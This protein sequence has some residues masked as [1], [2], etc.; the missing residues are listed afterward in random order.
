MKMA[1]NQPGFTNLHIM[2]HTAT[3]PVPRGNPRPEIQTQLVTDQDDPE[4]FPS[5]KLV[6]PVMKAEIIPSTELEMQELTTLPSPQMASTYAPSM[7]SNLLQK[8]SQVRRNGMPGGQMEKASQ[9][10]EVPT[11]NSNS[12]NEDH[13][14]DL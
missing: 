4:S 9:I 10:I 5:S 7:V 14:A 3:S 13:K 1:P 6:T 12:R 11:T 8:K 2:P